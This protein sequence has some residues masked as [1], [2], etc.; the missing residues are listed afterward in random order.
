MDRSSSNFF[1]RGMGSEELPLLGFSNELGK[2]DM[3]YCIL[4]EGD[5][6]L[7]GGRTLHWILMWNSLGE[8]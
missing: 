5:I 6:G 4:L 7:E 8:G 1:T 2:G 3:G